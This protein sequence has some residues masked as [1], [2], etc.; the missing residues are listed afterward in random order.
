MG[1]KLWCIV[2]RVVGVE[3]ASVKICA[4][5]FLKQVVFNTQGLSCGG[6]VRASIG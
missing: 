1:I 4:Y 5:T 2:G 6:V 3:L